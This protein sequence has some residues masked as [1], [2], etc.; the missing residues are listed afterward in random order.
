M[1]GHTSGQLEPFPKL[2]PNCQAGDLEAEARASA[3]R[4]EAE[5]DDDLLE[6]MIKAGGV[7]PVDA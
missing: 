2:Q 4:L 5:F 6:R 3:E 1:L 7:R